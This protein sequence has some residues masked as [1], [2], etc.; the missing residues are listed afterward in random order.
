MAFDEHPFEYKEI[1]CPMCKT[2]YFLEEEHDKKLTE[3][4]K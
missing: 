4:E 1:Q 2:E 3:L